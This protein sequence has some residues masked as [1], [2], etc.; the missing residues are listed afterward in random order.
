MERTRELKEQVDN[1]KLLARV[2]NYYKAYD[3][4]IA[5]MKK[6]QAK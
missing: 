5:N 2:V 4:K 6:Q 3:N 1:N